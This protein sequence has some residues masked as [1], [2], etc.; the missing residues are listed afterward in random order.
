MTVT[1][2]T[3]SA[4]FRLSK[5]LIYVDGE[6]SEVEVQKIVDFLDSF[7]GLDIKTHEQIMNYGLEQMDDTQAVKLIAALDDDAKQDAKAVARRVD[8]FFL[9]CVVDH[10]MS[11]KCAIGQSC[12]ICTPP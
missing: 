6:R 5:H 10:D 8:D 2:E 11:G 4:I 9:L 7:E 1:L 3:L 12:R